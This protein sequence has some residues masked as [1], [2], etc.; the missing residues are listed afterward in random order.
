MCLKNETAS[1]LSAQKEEDGEGKEKRKKKKGGGK[2][3][4]K[5]NRQNFRGP[6]ES[7]KIEKSFS[8]FF[9][10]SFHLI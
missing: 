6:A 7:K 8:F 3:A 4:K 1:H 5:I 2:N 9:L 10:L